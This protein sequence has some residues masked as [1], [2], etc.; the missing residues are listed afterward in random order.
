MVTTYKK[1]CVAFTLVELLVVIAIISILAGMLLPALENAIN[2]SR[3]ISCSS[4][5]KQ[6]L[7]GFQMYADDFNGYSPYSS[8]GSFQNWTNPPLFMWYHTLPP[9][10]NGESAFQCPSAPEEW[11]DMNY[12][13]SERWS[14]YRLHFG[15]P[16][17]SSGDKIYGGAIPLSQ[18]DYPSKVMVYGDVRPLYDTRNANRDSFF[19]NGHFAYY[20]SGLPNAGT[21]AMQP[22]MHDP[23]MNTAFPDGHVELLDGDYILTE[24]YAGIRNSILLWD[25][26]E[27]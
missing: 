13:H 20:A 24:W 16:K 5:Q 10:T 2:A 19:S 17:D 15:I 22:F 21:D 3:T 6:V 4:N 7:L 23:G 8:L 26:D 27:G 9:Y 14:L 1:K 12:S 18:L 11:G 25:T